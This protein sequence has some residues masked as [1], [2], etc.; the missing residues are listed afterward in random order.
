MNGQK[1]SR[2]TSDGGQLILDA[3]AALKES[4]GIQ[5]KV[6]P[7]DH[8]AGPRIS[9]AIA[10]TSLQYACEVKQ[11]IDRF[12][13][14]EDLKARSVID[15]S[16]ILVCPALTNALA[17]RCQQLDIQFIDTAGNSYITNGAG[18]LISVTGRKHE[19]AMRESH[20]A[21]V[22]PAALRII[23]GILAKP[24][25]LNA[26]YRDISMAV[27]VSTGAIAKAFETLETKG[28]IATTPSGTRL[29]RSPDLL[30]SEWATGF[31]HRIRP[32]LKKFRFTSPDP[33]ELQKW[34]PEFGLSAWGGEMAAELITQHLKPSS[35]TIYMDMEDSRTIYELVKR[36]RLRSDPHGA[37]EVIQPFWNMDEFA[38][39]FP[40]V[41]WH[42]VYA[43]LL[44]SKDSRNL[45]V[46]EQIFHK[47]VRHVQDSY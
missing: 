14:L 3:L 16:T 8:H 23:F 20:E 29:I 2:V 5:G 6:L 19:K 11:N 7:N 33:A 47:V 40:T 17:T 18:I 28:F 36:F 13:T 27:Q 42:L 10:E 31:M 38:E 43:D 41:P 34:N 26:P 25:M 45:Q 12:L 1:L 30:L 15:Q 32:K 35:F 39:S 4:T 46:A 22:T 37:I 44:G 9:L 24:S 21:T